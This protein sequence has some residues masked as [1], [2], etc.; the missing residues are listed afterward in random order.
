MF[1]FRGSL[2]YLGL[3]RADSQRAISNGETL[4]KS[5]SH[6]LSMHGLLR[7][8]GRGHID[9]GN[10]GWILVGRS[11]GLLDRYWFVGWILVGWISWNGVG[12]GKQWATHPVGEVVQEDPTTKD[13]RIWANCQNRSNLHVLIISLV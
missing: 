10:I 6:N 5:L 4:L 11:V 8:R 12:E 9:V 7:T 3:Y 2:Q 13:L 1:F